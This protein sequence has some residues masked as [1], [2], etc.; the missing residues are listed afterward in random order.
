MLN[1]RPLQRGDEGEVR[2]A[3][4]QMESEDF[5][6]AFELTAEKDW[7]AYLASVEQQRAGTSDLEK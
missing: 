5:T 2:D 3:H 1:L 6:F 4:R 7:D